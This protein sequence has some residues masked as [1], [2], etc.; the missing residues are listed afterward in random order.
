MVSPQVD[1]SVCYEDEKPSHGNEQ[2][3]YEQSH[4][5]PVGLF[6]FLDVVEFFACCYED[7]DDDEWC[8][9][10]DVVV[11]EEEEGGEVEVLGEEGDDC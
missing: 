1:G 3:P 6:P 11:D 4:G 7:E 9:K 2:E 8:D 10:D 5:C